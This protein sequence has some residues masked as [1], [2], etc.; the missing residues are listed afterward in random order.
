MLQ[1]FPLSFGPATLEILLQPI[2][3]TA[4]LTANTPLSSKFLPCITLRI[5]KR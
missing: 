3:S 2:F 1:K 4:T 5:V